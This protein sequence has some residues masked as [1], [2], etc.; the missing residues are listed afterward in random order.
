MVLDSILGSPRAILHLIFYFLLIY[1][2]FVDA[3]ARGSDSAE[4][5]ALACLLLPIIALFYLISR[6]EI[7]GRTEKASLTERAAGTYVI[8]HLLAILIPLILQIMGLSLHSVANSLG[9]LPYSLLLL[10]LGGLPGYLLVWKNGW[11]QIRHRFD[12]TQESE[13]AV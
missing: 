4:T 9:E 3:K 7:G 12:L 11:A 8:A 2:I 13:E 1:W 10:L 6:S 5:W